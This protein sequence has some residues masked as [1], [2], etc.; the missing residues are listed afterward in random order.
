MM[1]GV[2]IDGSL[3]TSIPIGECGE[4]LTITEKMI[5]GSKICWFH[6]DQKSMNWSFRKPTQP[7]YWCCYFAIGIIFQGNY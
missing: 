6:W 2:V 4:F 3:G 1:F 7:D 5:P